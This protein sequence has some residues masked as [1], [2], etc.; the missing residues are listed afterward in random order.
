MCLRIHNGHIKK[1]VKIHRYI[2]WAL[3]AKWACISCL[4]DLLFQWTIPF[5]SR[6]CAV[7]RYFLKSYGKT[8]VTSHVEQH[9]QF[10]TWHRK[11]KWEKKGRSRTPAGAKEI[12]LLCAFNCL[13]LVK[14]SM[15]TRCYIDYSHHHQMDSYHKWTQEDVWWVR[16]LVGRRI[17][18]MEKKRTASHIV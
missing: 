10:N 9:I 13:Q 16:V 15:C 11:G 6:F 18:K 8:G 1:I 12:K 5:F 4:A 17:N 14:S 3:L 2:L 7:L